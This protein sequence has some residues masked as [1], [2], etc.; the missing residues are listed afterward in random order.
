M[1]VG[2][3]VLV[4]VDVPVG[5]TVGVCVGVLVGVFVGATHAVLS[6]FGTVPPVHA[7]HAL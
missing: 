7:T 3:G 2:V 4:G 5:V 6:T 1:L